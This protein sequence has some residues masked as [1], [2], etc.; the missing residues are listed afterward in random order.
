MACQVE[1]GD[2]LTGAE[3]R[4]LQDEDRETQE[5]EEEEADD[6]DWQ[7]AARQGTRFQCPLCRSTRNTKSQ[8][9]KHIITHEMNDGPFNC[10]VCNYQSDSRDQV[11]EHIST[12]HENTENMTHECM[13]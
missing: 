13:S 11:N 4:E 10:E 12:A 7:L 6:G 5:D 2:A 3:E 9:L 1:A 8:I